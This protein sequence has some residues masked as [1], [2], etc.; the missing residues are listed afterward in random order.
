MPQLA[1]VLAAGTLGAV[2]AAHF[3]A[4]VGL[5][6]LPRGAVGHHFGLTQK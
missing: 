3:H 6:L 2:V 4:G 5:A 1:G